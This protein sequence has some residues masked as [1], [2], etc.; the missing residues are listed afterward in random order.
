MFLDEPALHLHPNKINVIKNKLRANSKSFNNQIILVTHSPAFIGN[1]L[2]IPNYEIIYC[3]RKNTVTETNQI[4]SEDNKNWIIENS[5]K[6]RFD[7]DPRILFSKHVILVEGD[8]E[9]GLL[10]GLAVRLNYE[11]HRNDI[12]LLP[13]E[14]K[15][16]LSK[17]VKLLLMYDIPYTVLVDRDALMDVSQENLSRI[18]LVEKEIDPETTSELIASLGDD[19]LIENPKENKQFLYVKEKLKEIQDTTTY[20]KIN[21]LSQKFL[22][23]P[24]QI[25][26]EFFEKLKKFSEEKNIFVIEEGNLEDLLMSVDSHLFEK[27]KSEYRSKRIR[28]RQFILQLDENKLNSLPIAKKILEKAMKS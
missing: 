8:S 5:E 13:V 3:V 25:R 17:F 23:R 9:L 4:G 11:L 16:S 7:F 1:D 10:Q 18:I 21:E 20:E 28:A 14:G 27:I 15:E 22:N 12:L 2:I 26:N 19:F 6:L 24:K